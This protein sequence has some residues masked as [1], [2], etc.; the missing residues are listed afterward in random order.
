MTNELTLPEAQ[1]DATDLLAACK[2]NAQLPYIK[3][4]GSSTN[5]CK[6]ELIG[7]GHWGLIRTKGEIDDLGKEVQ[8]YVIDGRVKAMTYGDNVLVTFSKSSELWKQI[9]AMPSDITLIGPEF[10]LFIPG[11]G[12]V[13]Y[14]MNNPTAHRIAKELVA[15][16]G[17][18]CTFKEHL[19]VGKKYKWHGPVFTACSATIA[20][21][22]PEELAKVLNAFKNAQDSK[23]EIADDTAAEERPR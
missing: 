9:E 8:L 18:A 1:S 13:T 16:R 3:L 10:L 22:D 7:I 11:V 21:P 23:V 6:E 17:K 20:V 2:S 5:E 12:F 14:H 15:F 19:I 4:C